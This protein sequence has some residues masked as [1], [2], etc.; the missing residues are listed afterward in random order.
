MTI[1]EIT[2]HLHEMA[3]ASLQ[4]S[5]DNTGLLVGDADALCTGILV[6]LDVT[7]EIVQEAIDRK[8]NLVVAHHPIIFRGLKKITGSNYVERTVMSAIRNH[9]A[10]FA[11]HTNL[12]NMSEGV[13]KMIAAK[14]KL[15]E[16]RVLVPRAATL[17]KLVTFVPHDHAGQV[18]KAMFDA[19]AGNVGNYSECSFSVK[20]EGSYKPGAGSNP[21]I[22]QQG[23]RHVEPETRM[24]LLLP[25]H[26]EHKVIASLRANHPYEEVAYYLQELK[27]TRSDRGSGLIG[28]LPGPVTETELLDHLKTVFHIP[29]IRHSPL[30]QH[31][32]HKIALCGGAGSFLVA[33]AKAAG[34]QVYITAD[35]KYHEFFDADGQ[36]VIADIGHYE[37]E[38]FTINLLTEFLQQKLPNFA[39]LKTEI[40]T[41]PVRYYS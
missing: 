21:A 27:N 9:V 24:E 19:G 26:L 18:R 29:V 3:P 32:V 35:M 20:G 8:C 36:I 30:L 28:N 31:K 6:S 5:Y 12:D 16:T 4:E 25:A 22:G 17:L 7:E 13:N 41:N 2:S 15:T 11:I 23:T 10:I 37:S 38:Q 33:N 34:A 40:N 1:A 14:L 39:V